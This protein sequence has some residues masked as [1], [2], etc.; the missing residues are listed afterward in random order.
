MIPI[1]GRTHSRDI[2]TWLEDHWK[3]AASAHTASICAHSYLDLNKIDRGHWTF[4]IFAQRVT[5]KSLGTWLQ[6]D[7][8]GDKKLA[9]NLMAALCY[10]H[11][12]TIQVH[13]GLCSQALDCL[14]SMLTKIFDRNKLLIYCAGY[15]F[16]IT[17]RKFFKILMNYGATKCQALLLKFQASNRD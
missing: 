4:F 17:L 10:P 1:N 11:H 7:D 8:A 12:A 15:D 14:R 3:H 9:I 5:E 13:T 2:W 16:P 6:P